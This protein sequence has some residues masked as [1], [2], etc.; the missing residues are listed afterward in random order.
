M[1][2]PIRF[3]P[4]RIRRT[5]L[6]LISVTVTLSLWELIPAL[7][8]VNPLF[9]SSPSRILRAAFELFAD[10]LW[11]DIRVS[12]TQFWLG[13][14]VAVLL[15]I[16][17]GLLLG[18]FPTLNAL[19]GPYVTVMY[20][21]PRVALLPLIILWLGIGLESKIAVVFLGAIF[22]I[23]V[24]S[25]TGVRSLDSNLLNCARAYGAGDRELLMTIALP[26]SIPFIIAGLRLGAGR[27]LVGVV[28]G[29]LIAAQAGVGHMMARAAATFQTDKVFVG[30]LLIALFGLLL[31]GGLSLLERRVDAWRVRR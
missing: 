7:N 6:A 25:M 11:L 13:Y 15:G 16:P 8:L 28:V 30:V 12:L 31:S 14:G 21:V 22:P 17:F 26:G 10:D 20:S 24:N 1:M 4:Q 9:T 27:G 3:L 5:L 18:W 2:H 29:E 19:F 23:I